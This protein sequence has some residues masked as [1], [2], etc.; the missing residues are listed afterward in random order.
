MTV[1]LRAGEDGCGHERGHEQ[2]D[3]REGEV[4]GHGG[5]HERGG[6]KERC[7]PDSAA[8]VETTCNARALS[9]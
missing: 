5:Q 7:D 4:G 2:S 8:L 9:R 3:Q 6:E 1:W